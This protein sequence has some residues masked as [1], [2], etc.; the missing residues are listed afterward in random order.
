MSCSMSKEQKLCKLAL[1]SEDISTPIYVECDKMYRSKVCIQEFWYCL[2]SLEL[3]LISTRAIWDRQFCTLK[4]VRNSSSNMTI[5]IPF[6]SSNC[7]EPMAEWLRLVVDSLETRVRLLHSAESFCPRRGH[8][9][10]HWARQCTDTRA[11]YIA[12]LSIIFF[13]WISSVAISR[14]QSCKS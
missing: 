6:F 5:H 9:A 7:Y 8:F 14:W 3:P 11:F 1:Q 12:A 10:W 2:S 4:A 13:S